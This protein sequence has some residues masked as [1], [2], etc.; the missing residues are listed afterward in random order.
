MLAK[1]IKTAWDVLHTDPEQ[2]REPGVVGTQS[3][4]QLLSLA[5]QAARPQAAD[6]R[7]PKDPTQWM[8]VDVDLARVLQAFASVSA[9]IGLPHCAALQQLLIG[10][11]ALYRVTRWLRWLFSTSSTKTAARARHAALVSDVSSRRIRDAQTEVV[12]GVDRA[13]SLASATNQPA[14]VMRGW[15][16]AA[17]E[18]YPVLE[19]FITDSHDPDDRRLV[20]TGLTLSGISPAVTQQIT[21]LRLDTTLL[22]RGLRIYQAFGAKFALVVHHALLGDEMGLGKTMQ[23]LAAIAHAIAREGQRRHVVLCPAALAD[24]WLAE[25]A[26]TTPTVTAWTFDGA[27]RDDAEEGWRARGGILLVSYDQIQHLLDADPPRFGFLVADEAHYV[28]NPASKRAQRTRQL[29]RYA[30]RVLLMGGTLMENRARELISL[31]GLADPARE[32]QLR[33]QFGD[34]RDAHHEPDEFRRELGE[35]YLRRNKEDVLD[36]LP[37]LIRVDVPVSVSGPQRQAYVDAIAQRNLAQA[38]MALAIDGQN[39][40]PKMQVLADLV[41]DSRAENHR[42]LIFTEFRSVLDAAVEVVGD[43]CYAIHGDVAKE[44]RREIVARF[45]AS[46]GF[47]ALVMQ[48]RVGGVGL[49][50]QAASVVVLLEPQYKPSTELQ[51]IGRAHRMGQRKDVTAYRLVAQDSIEKRIVALTS[52]KEELFDELAGKSNLAE[53]SAQ[54][55]DHRPIESQLLDDEWHRLGLGRLHQYENEDPSLQTNTD[56]GSD[57]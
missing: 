49:N 34:G 20:A 31:A 51:A 56:D 21:A 36:E 53:S 3:I 32:Q 14:D 47:G 8:A 37:D 45:Q 42:M 35:F 9:L 24:T 19:T 1:G 23:A 7:P 39:Q 16:S 2:L 40:T 52:F 13:R 41:S 43:D 30:N 6:L 22:T 57:L 29:A 15:R 46:S 38:R 5:Q 17:A 4:D 11:R 18:L 33:A 10:L 27:R 44:K 54:A 25:I 55:Q 26:K 50:L 12:R 28:K 48:I